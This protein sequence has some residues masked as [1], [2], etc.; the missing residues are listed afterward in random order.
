MEKNQ[1]LDEIREVNLMYLMLAQRLILEDRVQALY[2]LGITEETADL[3]SAM[4]AAQ[5]LKT[6][7]SSTL[8][9]NMR[10][11]DETVWNLLLNHTPGRDLGASTAKMHADILMARP[12]AVAS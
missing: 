8:V 1:L 12:L 11:A 9:C 5:I 3:V 7:S 2:R 10:S 6:A 4:S